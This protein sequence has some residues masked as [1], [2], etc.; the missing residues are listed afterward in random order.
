MDG[1]PDDERYTKNQLEDAIVSVLV[2]YRA[3]STNEV[4]SIVEA[5]RETV[6]KQ[7]SLLAHIGQIE[8]RETTNQDVWLTWKN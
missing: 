5:D 1:S 3:L 8:K 7:L 2:E 6:R 4:A